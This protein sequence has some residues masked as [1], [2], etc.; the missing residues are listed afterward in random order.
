MAKNIYISISDVWFLKLDK[1]QRLSRPTPWYH[2][3]RSPF[4]Y[5]TRGKSK[6]LLIQR[7]PIPTMSLQIPKSQKVAILTEEGAKVHV[8]DHPVKSPDDLAPG[9]CLVK[10]HCSGVCHTDLHAS[11]G[12][13]PVKSMTPLIGGHEGVGEII[14]IGKNTTKSPVKIGQRVGIKWIADSCF[15]CE[16]C[17]K[18]YEQSGLPRLNM[19]FQCLIRVRLRECQAKRLYC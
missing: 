19:T 12:D 1:G 17:R 8:Q 6:G 10:M 2:H 14:A 3:R 15:D 7:I 11:L 13:W 16:Q 18:G 4:P 5:K 9:E